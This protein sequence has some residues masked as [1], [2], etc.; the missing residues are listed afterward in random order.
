M[1]YFKRA[2]NFKKGSSKILDEKIAKANQEFKKTGVLEYELHEDDLHEKMSTSGMYYADKEIPAI[3]AEYT[4]VP[5]PNGVTQPGYT[6][7]TGGHDPNDPSTWDNSFTDTS[8]LRNPNEVAGETNRQAVL[9]LPDSMRVAAQQSRGGAEQSARYPDAAGEGGGF[10]IA[11]PY[12]GTAL[13]YLGSGG[14]W[15]QVCSGGLV[16]GTNAPHEGS[17]GY[18]GYYNGLTDEEFANAVWF[19]ETYQDLI[20]EHGIN[21]IPTVASSMWIPWS[22]F[23]HGSA[24]PTYEEYPYTKRDGMVLAG[25]SIVTQGNKYESSPYVPPWNQVVF[26]DDL[27]NPNNLPIK[28]LDEILGDLYEIGQGAIDGLQDLVGDIAD[29]F[30]DRPISNDDILGDMWS[31]LTDHWNDV[32][33][34]ITNH[35]DV[36]QFGEDLIDLFDDIKEQLPAIDYSVDI[37]SSVLQGKPIDNSDSISES[38]I[39]NLIDNINYD[40]ISINDDK[41]PY[42]DDNIITD[43]DGNVRPRNPWPTDENGE[44]LPTNLVLSG[45]LTDEQQEQVNAWRDD[46]INHPNNTGQ[47]HSDESA[48]ELHATAGQSNPLSAAGQ[49]QTQIYTNE[50]GELIF[51]FTDHAYHNLTSGD[52]GE[53]PDPIKDAISSMVHTVSDLLHDRGEEQTPSTIGVLTPGGINSGPSTAPNTGDMSGY[54]ANIRGDSIYQFERPVSELSPEFQDWVH[55]QMNSSTFSNTV[56]DEFLGGTGQLL[57]EKNYL[58][59]RREAR[60]SKQSKKRKSGDKVSSLRIDGPKDHL[61]VKAVDMLR[62]H[63]LTE[64]EKKEYARKVGLINQWIRDNPKEYE[65]WKVRYPKKDPRLATL[66]WELDQRLKSSEEYLETRFPENQKLYAKLKKKIKVNID[67]TDPKRFKKEKAEIVYPKL[68]KVSKAIKLDTI[69]PL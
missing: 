42:A 63:Y 30:N 21:N 58:R 5:D 61:T 49:A 44:E 31:D 7:P 48:D 25:C 10:V 51:S 69:A 14:E 32:K 6:P 67:A 62:N 66:N 24:A 52:S 28:P 20:A 65:I 37:A 8:W 59:D 43:E 1:S 53:V 38:D 50:N 27:G 45:D 55:S 12:W 9:G 26:Q 11:S 4:P 15:R 36:V 56:A 18:G 19:W 16:G 46:H 39:D 2:R 23:W 13:G 22:Y 3:P 33:D 29:A 64:L 17:R 54:P 40:N 60:R 68:L 41:V 35:D 47:T 57:I 34:N